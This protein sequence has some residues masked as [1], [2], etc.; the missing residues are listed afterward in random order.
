VVDGANYLLKVEATDGTSTGMD[1][2]D[3]PFEIANEFM[4]TTPIV[5][6]LRPNGG[7]R[8]R[9][10]YEIQW[11]A[12]D[13]EGDPL[14]YTISYS[15]NGGDTWTL[16]ASEVTGTSYQW[17]T[18]GVQVGENYLIKIE[19][20]D[21][22]LTTEDCSDYKFAVERETHTATRS[23]TFFVPSFR[24]LEALGA[25]LVLLGLGKRQR[26]QKM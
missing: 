8:V 22:R 4:N 17:D 24:V 14:T 18:S 13:L 21:G 23:E 9:V 16:L 12:T 5:L 15:P 6:V 20:S 1:L 25:L 7:E 26:R 19:A 2:S 10:I 11:S 3:A